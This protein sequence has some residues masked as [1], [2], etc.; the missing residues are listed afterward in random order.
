MALSGGFDRQAKKPLK[1]N[2]HEFVEHMRSGSGLS[3]LRRG[4]SR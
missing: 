3:W 1:V 4:V 2:K